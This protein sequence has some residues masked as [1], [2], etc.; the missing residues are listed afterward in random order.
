MK[1]KYK[2]C[3]N[4]TKN[5]RQEGIVFFICDV[6]EDRIVLLDETG[7]LVGSHVF[8]SSHLEGYCF[9]GD[10]IAVVTSSGFTGSSVLTTLDS[11]GQILESLSAPRQIQALSANSDA[12][13]VLYA[14]EE[15]TLYDRMLTERISYQPD[16]DVSKALLTSGELAYYTGPGGVTQIDF[17]R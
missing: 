4:C 13:L 6:T 16:S 5:I 12:L 11:G 14:G 17:S 8:D 3:V 10:F 15:S 1:I 9:D 7:R 2:I